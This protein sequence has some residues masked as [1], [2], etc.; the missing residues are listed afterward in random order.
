MDKPVDNAGALPTALPTL[1]RLSPTIPQDQQQIVQQNNQKT[2]VLQIR[3]HQFVAN[4]E[5]CTTKTSARD[6]AII[7]QR[8][9]VPEREGRRR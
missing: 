4:N 8:R 3:T 9:P 1:S 2:L 6:D 5:G 7:D